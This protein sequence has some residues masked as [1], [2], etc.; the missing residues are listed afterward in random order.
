MSL[1]KKFY[2]LASK[3][4]T[5]NKEMLRKLE[6]RLLQPKP[7]K[8]YRGPTSGWKEFNKRCLRLTFPDNDWIMRWMKMFRVNAYIEY[9]T[10]DIDFIM[11]L[12]TKLESDRLKWNKKK[13]CF[14]L[15]SKEGRRIKI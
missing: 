14:Y 4:P 7:I 3:L 5:N 12:I 1:M 8:K 15:I 10:W 11:E 2:R 13:K 9:N 6:T